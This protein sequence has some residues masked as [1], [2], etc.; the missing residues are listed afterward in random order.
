MLHIFKLKNIIIGILLFYNPLY[1]QSIRDGVSETLFNTVLA[2]DFDLAGTWQGNRF[3]VVYDSVLNEVVRFE[4]IDSIS[5]LVFIRHTM[6]EDVFYKLLPI[7]RLDTVALG[8]ITVMRDSTKFLAFSQMNSEIKYKYFSDAAIYGSD[9]L[10]L[11]IDVPE[12]R[13][14]FDKSYEETEDLNIFWEFVRYYPK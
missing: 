14:F 6:E 12:S 9:A 13:L 11:N 4:F 3:E 2:D 1:S 8:Q 7:N 5:N 10:Q